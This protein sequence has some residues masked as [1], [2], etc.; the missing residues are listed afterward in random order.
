MPYRRLPNTDKSRI[1]A[2]TTA[3]DKS[4]YCTPDELAFSYKTLQ[5][6]KFFLPTYKQSLFHKNVGQSNKNEK[7][8]AYSACKKKIKLYI[9]HFIQVVQFGILREEYNNEILDYYGL[10][11]FPR[12]VPPLQSDDDIITW[13]QKIIKGEDARV[14]KGETPILNPRIALVK[15]HFQKFLEAQRNHA[16]LTDKDDR[17]S[18]YINELRAEAHEIIVQ[19]WDEVEKKFAHI[20]PPEERRKMAEEYGLKYVF[21]PAELKKINL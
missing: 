3:I 5:R 9:S 11:K 18:K 1:Q 7:G 17:A 16:I 12:K 19:I 14:M 8:S 21:R 20:N 15:I 13:G 2:L 4:S 10:E 6:A